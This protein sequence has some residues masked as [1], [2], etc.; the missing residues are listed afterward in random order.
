MKI[1]HGIFL[2]LAVSNY[3][4]MQTIKYK[5]Q[6]WPHNTFGGKHGYD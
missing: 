4:D 3:T 6:V 2:Y 5:G 1:G